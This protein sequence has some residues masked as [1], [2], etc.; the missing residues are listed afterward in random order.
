MQ[1]QAFQR[2]STAGR[3]PCQ[4]GFKVGRMKQNK[5]SAIDFPKEFW[6]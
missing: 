6:L 5:G 4:S 3:T 2:K 1:G